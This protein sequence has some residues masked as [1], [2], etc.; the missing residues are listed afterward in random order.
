MNLITTIFFLQLII[1]LGI[2]IVKIYNLF[3]L[4]K[5]YD[6]KIGFLLLIITIICFLMG[7]LALFNI[8]EMLILSQIFRLEAWLYYFHYVFFLAEIFFAFAPSNGT[9]QYKSNQQKQ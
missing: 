6:L 8:P 9:P 7:T 1:F 5:T 2:F 4:G 3:N